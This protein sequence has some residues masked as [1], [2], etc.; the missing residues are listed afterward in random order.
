MTE[1]I[2]DLFLSIDIDE[3]QYFTAPV[4]EISVTEAWADFPAE[5]APLLAVGQQVNL[6]FT[7]LRFTGTATVRAWVAYREEEDDGARC[8][9]FQL[10]RADGTALYGAIQRR[11]WFRVTPDPF[12]PVRI[13]LRPKGKEG[14]TAALLNDIS[15]GGLS[16]LINKEEEWAL[17]GSDTFEIAL[18]LPG[19]DAQI[20][21]SGEVRYRRL[22][23]A[24]VQ[25]GIRF[26][27]EAEGFEEQRER[28]RAYVD[29]RRTAMM[30]RLGGA[31]PDDAA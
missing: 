5:Q 29:V 13:T 31:K 16:A 17:A 8:Y 27:P 25:Y 10:D 19:C 9:Q 26:H 12:H 20:G 1:P 6:L 3:G 21:F 2:P 18:R 7:G 28:V 24:A 14:R 15:E 23:G 11:H 30:R 22:V 4:R